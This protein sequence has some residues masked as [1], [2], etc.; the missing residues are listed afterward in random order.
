MY[1]YVYTYILLGIDMLDGLDSECIYPTSFEEVAFV[2]VE[3]EEKE[4]KLYMYINK[5]T[6]ET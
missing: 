2:L 3:Q 5:E 1:V 4:K 6:H